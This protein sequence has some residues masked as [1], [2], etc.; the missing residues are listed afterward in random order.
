MPSPFSEG[1]SGRIEASIHGPILF[2]GT[3]CSTFNLVPY[4]VCAYLSGFTDRYAPSKI[5][6][7]CQS[8]NRKQKIRRTAP[9]TFTEP[10][11]SVRTASHTY[12]LILRRMMQFADAYPDQG[13]VASLVRQ[14][15]WTLFPSISEQ[16]RIVLS[17]FM[18]VQPNGG[19]VLFEV[20]F[21][22]SSKHGAFADAAAPHERMGV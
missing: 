7:G 13:I 3:L 10:I 18:L 11:E 22:K 9:Y 8:P 6:P 12:D 20:R 19:R 14:L 21:E 4:V 16:I 17:A 5:T 2:P 1:T 15:S